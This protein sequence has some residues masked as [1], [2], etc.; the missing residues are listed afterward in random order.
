[1][2]LTKGKPEDPDG[3][4]CFTGHVMEH[5][6][7]YHIFYP[8]V[9]R[10]HPKGTMQM[11]HA[12]SKDVINFTKHPEE[13]WGPDGIH[14]KTKAQTP[15]RKGSV[16]QPTFKDQCVVWNEKEKKWWM[17]FSAQYVSAVNSTA[18]AVSDDLINWT[19][20]APIKGLGPGDCTDVF[21]IDD[22]WYRISYFT[23]WRAKDLA[24]PWS[25][26][27]SGVGY[28]FDTPHFFVP[29]RC[30]DGKRHVLIGGMRNYYGEVDHTNPLAPHCVAIPREVYAD[31]EGFL[32][33]RPVPEVTA[34]FNKIVLDLAKKP[35]PEVSPL[36]R[37]WMPR[38]QVTPSWKY[39][40]NVLVN[41][42]AHVNEYSHCS[43]D[44]PDDYMLKATIQLDHRAVLTVGFREQKGDRRSGY[45][46]VMNR[47]TNEIEINS[48]S[49]SYPRAVKLNPNKPVTVQAFLVGSILECWVN[50][51]HAFSLRDYD[52]P[53]GKLSFD[54]V[55]GRAWIQRMTVSTADRKR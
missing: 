20:V 9:N 51:A 23:Y 3:E 47:R 34:V 33:T 24:G 1:M 52:Y 44:V 19:Q 4:Y 25:K 40:G 31:A 7:T 48:P 55:Y 35:K 42:A 21:K 39:E 10:R 18:L 22:W 17:F 5:E 8:G 43:F 26:N 32:C 36:L 15:E 29:K 45:K 12:T 41:A 16:E 38:G 13:T 46:L 37:S 49:A 11:M 2:A 54:V 50:D 30:F 14:Y 27:D 6:G 28:D 53:N